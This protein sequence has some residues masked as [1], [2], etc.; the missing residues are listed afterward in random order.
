MSKSYSV[1]NSCK[2]MLQTLAF[3]GNTWCNNCPLIAR[4]MKGVYCHRR[5][6]PKCLF[7]WDVSCVLQFLSSFYPLEEL[8]LKLLTFKVTA[9][10]ALAAA[11]RAPTL[12]YMNLDDMLR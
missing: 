12:V 9:L 11:P 3:F 6:S 4:F 7:T 2:A 8:S 5:P 1:I 10:I